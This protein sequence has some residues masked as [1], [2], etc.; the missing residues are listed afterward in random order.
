MSGCTGCLPSEREQQQML[1]KL[2]NEAKA[3]AVQIQKLVFI[4]VDAESNPL[5]IEAEAGRLAGYKPIQF[6]SYL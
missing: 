2:Y 1:E 6:V 5:Y 3:Y 4:Y